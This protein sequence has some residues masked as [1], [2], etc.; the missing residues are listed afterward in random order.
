MING[1]H[2]GF[3][4]GYTGKNVNTEAQNHVTVQQFNTV[5]KTLIYNEVSLGRYAGPF[6][7]PP[8][9]AFQ[10]SP[11]KLTPKKKPGEFRLLHNLS[12]PYDDT[13]V[14][15]N[16][17]QECTKV[18]YASIQDAINYILKL[19][20]GCYMAKSDIKSA[21]RLVPVH[22]EDYYLLGFKFNG[23]YFYDRCLAQGCASSCKIFEEISTALEWILRNKFHVPYVVHVL[24]DFLKLAISKPLCIRYQISWK[25]LCKDLCIPIAP[26]KTEG[27]DQ[28][29]TFVGIQLS[30]I[31]MIAQLP[32][33]KLRKYSNMIYENICSRKITLHDMQ[34]IIG[35]LQF[36]TSVVVPGKAFIRRLIDTTIGIKMPSHY[37]T[38]NKEAQL[39]LE[40]W[41]QFLKY[42]NGKTLITKSAVNS[43]VINLHTDASKRACAAVF[44]NNWF[45]IEFT[46]KFKSYNIAFLEL[47]PIVIAMHIFGLQ[48]ANT[49]VIFHCDNKAIT[50]IINKQSSKDAKIMVLV[51]KLVMICMQYNITFKS[52]HV[53]GKLNILPDKLSRFQVSPQLLREYG[54]ERVP[55]AVPD[56]LLPQNFKGL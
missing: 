30:S 29:M 23:K 40:M 33:D 34:S 13:S 15:K 43:E 26:E 20:K 42:H 27:P 16:I 36:A 25:T 39:D 12:Y 10:I 11:L 7:N 3:R 17:P 49:Y 2:Q 18:S 56:H 46:D 52:L 8:F 55:V 35:C 51:R 22:P 6:D 50:Q 44:K 38:I 45:V 1:F 31:D 53:P 9:N 19:G 37:V 47:Y 5:A 4:L 28:V 21:F 14:N 24:D 48:M 41:G 54:M 32:L